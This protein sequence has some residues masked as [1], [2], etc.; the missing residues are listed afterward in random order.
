MRNM[1]VFGAQEKG[2]DGRSSRFP[3]TMNW[4]DF[5]DERFTVNG[6]GWW[7]ETKPQLIRLPQRMQGIVPPAV[8][9][10]AQSPSAGR[11]TWPLWLSLLVIALL[12]GAVL[13]WNELT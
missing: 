11:T 7:D 10:L 9:G 6:L 12:L 13:T 1:V 4:I 8:W 3:R 2:G 5:P